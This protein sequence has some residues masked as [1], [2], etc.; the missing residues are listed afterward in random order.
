ME[1]VVAFLALLELIKRHIVEANQE[2]NFGDIGLTP[3]A[4]WNE[5]EGE[6]EFGE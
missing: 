6:L 3:I 1:V 2:K 5:D 4:E